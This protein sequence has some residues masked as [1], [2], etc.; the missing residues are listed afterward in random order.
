MKFWEF[1][2]V[3]DTKVRINRWLSDT[4]GLVDGGCVYSTLFEYTADGQILPMDNDIEVQK[5]IQVLKLNIE[6]LKSL[7]S[8][9][10]SVY[11]DPDKDDDVIKHEM[12]LDMII[13]D[14]KLP[15]FISVIKYHYN[16]WFNKQ[17]Y[18]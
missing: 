2:K 13:K 14:D 5:T 18:A 7:R 12:E 3:D 6:K 16:A 8:E 17:T 9:V 4:M 10:L 1:A 15:A 11:I